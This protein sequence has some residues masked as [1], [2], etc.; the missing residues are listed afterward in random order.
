[1]KDVCDIAI[2]PIGLHHL[3]WYR[4][5]PLTLMPELFS[6]FFYGTLLH[7]SILRRVIGHDGEQLEIC[8]ALLLEHTRHKVKHAD[9]PAVLPYDKSCGLFTDHEREL[10]PEERTVRG[11]LVTGL[12]ATD[13]EFLDVFEGNQYTRETV[14]VYPLGP[15]T[16]LSSSDPSSSSS[17]VPLTPPP[18]PSLASLGTPLTTQ[19]YIWAQP[20]SD[21]SPDLWEYADFVRTNAWKWVG[22]GAG[23]NADYVEVDHRRE[24]GRDTAHRSGMCTG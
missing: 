24:M 14:P 8:P 1:M 22:E 19:T 13:I 18:L 23:N 5:A 20:L 2:D 12:S 9:Y 17:L 10:T 15:F 21:L 11:T 3:L 7:P 6:A 16:S 4:K